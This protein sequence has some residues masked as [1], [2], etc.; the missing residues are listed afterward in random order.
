MRDLRRCD[1]KPF[2][3]ATAD[4]FSGDF[5]QVGPV[6]LFGKRADVVEASLIYSHL[7]KHVHTAFST[8]SINER[9]SRQ[10]VLQNCASCRRFRTPRSLTDFTDQGTTSTDDA[11]TLRGVSQFQHL[12]DFVYSDIMTADPT[13]FA[14]RGILFPTNVCSTDE[15]NEH[16]HTQH[17][18]S[19]QTHTYSVVR[20]TS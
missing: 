20:T 18:A 11:C 8:R 14:N 7:W 3:G 4:L 9:S 10:G 2:G 6:V 1:D 15:I 17:L 12:I 13:E 16:I 5:R 19:G